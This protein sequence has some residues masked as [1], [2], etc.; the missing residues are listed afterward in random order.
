[1]KQNNLIK[2]LKGSIILVGGYLA[3]DVSYQL[4]KGKMLGVISRHF[5]DDTFGLKEI[6]HDKKKSDPIRLKIVKYAADLEL[7]R[8]ES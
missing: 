2:M 3:M 6:I 1:M 8:G 4:G 7:E 5:K